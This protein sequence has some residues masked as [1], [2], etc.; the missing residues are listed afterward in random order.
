MPA[1]IQDHI[2]SRARSRVKQ[3]RSNGGPVMI[4]FI[5]PR[6]KMEYLIGLILAAGVGCFTTAIGLSRDRSFYP[7]VLI[8]I[9]SYYVL[10]AAMGAPGRTVMVE[11]VVASVFLLFGVL[12]F[13]W[14]LWIVVVALVGHGLFDFVHH[15]FIDNPGVPRWW[16]GFCLAFDALLG[17][18]L[19]LRLIR[20][21]RLAAH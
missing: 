21:P 1:E 13:K 3:A 10:F 12:G 14:N 4:K 11:S 18:F 17:M 20:H 15:F 6:P 7:T 5:Y 16:P 2:E 19:V 8:V 9:G